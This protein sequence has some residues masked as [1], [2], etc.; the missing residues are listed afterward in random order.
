MKESAVNQNEQ[1]SKYTA[2]IAY[3]H[4]VMLYVMR[5]PFGLFPNAK[6][7]WSARSAR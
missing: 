2:R 5:S 7:N 3:T 4:N 1:T 6:T